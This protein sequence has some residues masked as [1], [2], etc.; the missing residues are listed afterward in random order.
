M[1]LQSS[2][3]EREQKTQLFN[4]WAPFYDLLFPSVF[5]QALH[6][7]VLDYLELPEKPYVLDLGC[8]TGRLLQRLAKS[9]PELS[10]V[11]LDFSPEMLR[12]ARKKS[13]RY[14][15]RLI[16]IQGDAANLPTATAQFDAVFNTISFLHY[17]DPKKV[18]SEVYRTLKPQGKYYLVD[19][20]WKGEEDQIEL[21][22][23]TGKIRLYSFS[24]REKM[25]REIGFSSID[26]HWLLASVGL[27]IF[28][29]N[30]SNL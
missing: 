9:F 15:P 16:Y 5:Y 17:P 25:G 22:L 3:K 10:G 29:K 7:R 26:H 19:F 20:V 30:S 2:E 13:R 4:L 27:T 1:S 6:L 23:E 24:Q 21:G 18:L 11:G 12:Q 28:Q 14:A 8:G